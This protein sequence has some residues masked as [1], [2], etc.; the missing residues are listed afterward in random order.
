MMDLV[1]DINEKLRVAQIPLS[2]NKKLI[3]KQR[4]IEDN[5]IR[6]YNLLS[7][8]NLEVPI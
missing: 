7:R 4:I 2:M 3:H 6:L 8:N 1:L 5:F